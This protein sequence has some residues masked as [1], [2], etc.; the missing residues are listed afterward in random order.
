MTGPTNPTALT[1]LSSSLS[2]AQPFPD[3]IPGIIPFGSL[4]L[5]VGP[6]KC[7]KTALLASWMALWRDGLTI[8]VK[9]TNSPTALGIITTDHK[10]ALNQGIWFARAGFPEIPHVSLR[11]D[12]T[13][14][15]RSTLR[16]VHGAHQLLDRSLRTLDLSPGGLVL[17]DVAGVFISNRLNDYNDVL[18]G[19]GDWR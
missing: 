14:Q 8:C 5:L 15:W 19:M 2:L 11:D 12:P 3:P 10:W 16:S 18:A 7:G 17:I 13:L 4:V 1:A 9:P 6:P